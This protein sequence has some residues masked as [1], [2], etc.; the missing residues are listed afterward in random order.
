MKTDLENTMDSLIWSFDKKTIENMK[1]LTT[2]SERDGIEHGGILCRD[3]DNTKT[4]AKITLENECIGNACS[5]KYPSKIC[6]DGN[7]RL[8]TFHTH[9]DNEEFNLSYKD[10]QT[11]RRGPS[12]I[13]C[14]GLG[15]AEENRNVICYDRRRVFDLEEMI[16]EDSNISKNLKLKEELLIKKREITEE[17]NKIREYKKNYTDKFFYASLPEFFQRA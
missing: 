13:S 2:E 14:I 10:I 7:I 5:I 12:F 17:L 6:K 4:S 11:F 15:K 1:R 8:G 3:F 9:P 16:K